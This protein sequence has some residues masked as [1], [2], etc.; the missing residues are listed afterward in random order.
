MI[1]LLLALPASRGEE[2]KKDASPKEKYAALVKD[3]SAKQREVIAEVQKA[4]GK[5]RDALMQKYYGVGKEFADKF[6][7]LAEDNAADPVAA[8]ALVWVVQN[9][10]GS[11]AFEKALDKLIAKYPDNPAIERVCTI[12]SRGGQAD[13]DKALKLIAEK[14]SKPSV[15]AAATFA[16]AKL[17]AAK[18]D[19]LGAK[20]AEADKVASEAEKL[21]VMAIEL[22]KDNAA[23][24]KAAEQELKALK[25]LRV[26]KEAPEIKA[27]D[28][29]GKEFKLSDYRGKVVLLDFWGNW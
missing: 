3:F 5:E 28:L 2:P 16:L 7:K 23:Q 18:L 17:V 27:T 11:Q 6:Y 13:A 21:Y 29:D 14:T 10:A 26:G 4:S 20:P 24:K 9:A 8:D 25:T 22:L 12:L 1:V 19:G 15:K